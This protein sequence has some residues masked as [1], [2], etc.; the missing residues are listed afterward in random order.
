MAEGV[1]AK[2]ESR[3]EPVSKL[4]PSS[5][6]AKLESFLKPKG[7]SI[8]TRKSLEALE[9][10]IQRPVVFKVEPHYHVE[11]FEIYSLFPGKGKGSASSRDDKGNS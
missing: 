5:T 10:K 2:A 6:Q 3:F 7:A 11:Q 4:T 8:E 9:A 1:L